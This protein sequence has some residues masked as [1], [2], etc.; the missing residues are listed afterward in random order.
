MID[1]I[2]VEKKY[3]V[4]FYFVLLYMLV[5]YINYLFKVG[6]NDDGIWRWLIVIFFNVKI[7]GWLDIKNFV[8]YFYNEV[9][10]VIM[11]WIIEGVE[12]VIKVNFKLILL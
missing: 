2:L 7:I 3:K 4:F 11:F 9:V 6:V 10:L 5:F 12:K 8:D 1:E